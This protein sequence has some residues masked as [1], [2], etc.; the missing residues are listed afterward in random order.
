[1]KLSKTIHFQRLP[2]ILCHDNGNKSRLL[3]VTLGSPSHYFLAKVIH[4]GMKWKRHSLLLSI[5]HFYSLRQPPAY[6]KWYCSFN[7]K[8]VTLKKGV[9]TCS[10]WVKVLFL[11]KFQGSL[12]QSSKPCLL[13]R[14][15]LPHS[16]SWTLLTSNATLIITFYI[17][18]L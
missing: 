18:V 12:V 17:V 7:I 9:F 5:I 13:H 16:S 14:A 4:T 15:N 3:T 10:P 11:S 1:M 8:S 6:I 2:G